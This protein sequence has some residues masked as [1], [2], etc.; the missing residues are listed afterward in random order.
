MSQRNLNCMDIEGSK[1]YYLNINRKK[2]VKKIGLPLIMITFNIYSI[3]CAYK[4]HRGFSH[5]IGW[6]AAY[7]S[8]CFVSVSSSPVIAN[9]DLIN[10]RLAHHI[11]NLWMG[12]R[13]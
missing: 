1:D 7:N 13:T 10:W 8:L 4:L 2:N 6:L 12:G 9:E 11:H 3:I 5:S